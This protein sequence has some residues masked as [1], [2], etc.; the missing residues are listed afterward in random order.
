MNNQSTLW[1]E[2]CITALRGRFKHIKDPKTFSRDCKVSLTDCLMACFGVFSLKWP[3]L[4]QYEIN[5]K[6]SNLHKNFC[7]L[8]KIDQ[9][10]SDTYMRERLDQLSTQDL[11]PAYK[12]IFSMLQ[13]SKALEPYRYL[14]GYYI[15]SI[16]GTGHFSSDKVHCKNCCKK[17]HRNGKITYYHQMLAAV[18]VHPELKEVVPFCPEPI[19]KGD[20]D[21]KNDCERNAAKRLIC[22]LR[23]EHPHLKVMVVEDGL[24]SN[25][26]HIRE[27][28]GANMRY[29]L[30]VKERGPSLSF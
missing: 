4:L 22:N 25:G 28:E 6:D 24:A 26:P 17:E 18:M 20:G 2:R 5:L 15:V 10:P 23:R 16:D 7:R 13:R 30:G 27:L 9:V 8:Y 14:D 12:K 1:I 3:S 29:V 19:Q 11:A 21:T